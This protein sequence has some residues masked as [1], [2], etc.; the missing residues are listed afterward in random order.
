MKESG[1]HTT[2]ASRGSGKRRRQPDAR[3]KKRRSPE[4]REKIQGLRRQIALK[5][6]ERA[7]LARDVEAARLREGGIGYREQL[8]ALKGLKQELFQLGQQLRAAKERT[9]VRPETGNLPDFSI[10]GAAKC[11]TTFLYHLLVKHP[12][13]DPAAFK[14]PHFFD[15][16]FDRGVDWYR[17]CFPVPRLHDGSP[18]I[19]G[20][21]TPGYLSHPDVPERMAGVAP[22]AK[23]IALLRNPVDM[24][25]SAYNFFGRR[26]GKD[27]LNFEDKANA[28]L[29]DPDSKF[30]SKGVYVD[31]LLRW[32]RHFDR[33]Q[34]LV[35]KSE[36]FFADPRGT[37]KSVLDFLDLPAW[38]TEA[39][40]LGEKRNEGSYHKEMEAYTRRRLAEFYAPHNQR[41]YEYLGVDFGW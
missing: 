2:S 37:L 26:K 36:D 28:A 29:G 23:L 14:V 25:Y 40:D 20:E 30:L 19:T 39:S 4:R 6:K 9:G 24:L 38:E 22:D 10:I 27:A 18:T 13:V 12:H 31:Q 35:L 15:M 1:D 33:E 3:G 5:R 16:Q 17:R 7:R 11:G 32:S 34:M 41:L 8:M 21:A